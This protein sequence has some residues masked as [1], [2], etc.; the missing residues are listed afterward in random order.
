MEQSLYLQ[1]V[2][3]A[4]CRQELPCAPDWPVRG[5]CLPLAVWSWDGAGL[6]SKGA[7]HRVLQGQVGFIAAGGGNVRLQVQK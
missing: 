4:V 2:F 1:F 3:P 6:Q 7:E 5:A